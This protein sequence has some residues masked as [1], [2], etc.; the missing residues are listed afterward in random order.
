MSNLSKVNETDLSESEISLLDI[1]EF[2][3]ESWKTIVGFIILGI[4][5]AALFFWVVP[6]QYEASAQIKMAQIANV[7]N[8]NNNI[9][10]LGIN[11]EEPQALIA[12]MALPTS[13][14]KETIALCGLTDEKDADA[15]LAKK[16]KLSIPRGVGGTVDLKVRDASKEIT[17]TCANAVYQLIKTSQ[18]QLV[19][20]Y[21]DEASKKLKIEEERLARATQV[22]AKADKSGAAVSAAYLATRD[23]IRYLLDQISNLQSIITGNESRAAHLT[24]PI[25]LKDGPV[26]PQKRNSLL[27]GLLLGGF[28]GLMLALARKWYRSNRAVLN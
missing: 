13:Y 14:P 1:I 19:A 10:P 17:Q 24:A 25:Y 27:I 15:Q 16:V 4:A 2:I 9:N 21:I 7:N 28:L 8:N 5:G 20:P 22:I 26:F 12:R 3:Q 23:E 18:A 6:K 11:V